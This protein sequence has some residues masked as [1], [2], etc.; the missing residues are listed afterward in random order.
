[1]SALLLALLLAVQDG[2]DERYVESAP[3]GAAERPAILLRTPDSLPR[4]APGA[5][6]R[7]AD[8]AQREAV[9]SDLGQEFVERMTAAEGDYL[10]ERYPTALERLYGVLEDQ[11]DFP[12]ALMLLG[13]AYFRLRRYEDCAVALERFIEVAPGEVWRTQALGHCYYSLGDYA[14]ARAHYERLLAAMPPELGAS[15]EA[16]RGLALCHMRQGDAETAL[17]LLDQVLELRPDHAEACVFRARILLGLD[18]V[19]EALAAAER[20]RELA[21]Y[22]PQGWYLVMRILYDLGRDEEAHAAEERWK[23]LDRVAQEVRSL[24]MQLRFHPGSYPIV[25]RLCELAASIGDVPGA[26]KRLADLLLARPA[27]VPEV[28]LRVLVLDVLERLE[29]AEGAR[30]AALALEETCPDEVETWERLTRYYAGVRDRKN[31]MRC[32]EEAARLSG[33]GG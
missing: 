10:A 11:P 14:K 27:D 15:V 25:L 21:P 13:T 17:K 26:R 2:Q 16:M 4:A 24:E 3:P 22:E 18:R 28:K 29:D 1:V 7:F 30:V 20:A 32:A 6:E 31:Q 8:P 33:K 9:V 19:E 5:W 12:P 23:E